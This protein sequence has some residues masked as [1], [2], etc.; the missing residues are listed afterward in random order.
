LAVPRSGCPK[1]RQK[2]INH[3]FND[4]GNS[5]KTANINNSY[6]L[7]YISGRRVAVAFVQEIFLR[8]H[9]RIRLHEYCLLR[10]RAFEAASGLAYCLHRVILQFAA[11]DDRT[12]LPRTGANVQKIGRSHQA[13]GVL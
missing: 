1:F 9:Q 6:T 3:P 10:N 8:H 2:T 7:C 13:N 12:I 4:E 5:N 11:G